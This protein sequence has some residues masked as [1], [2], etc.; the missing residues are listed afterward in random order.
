[1]KTISNHLKVDKYLG[2]NPCCRKQKL[3]VNP[4]FTIYIYNISHIM[5]KK[6]V[7]IRTSSCTHLIR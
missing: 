5:V 7:T 1:M 6:C 2:V 3:I 4:L